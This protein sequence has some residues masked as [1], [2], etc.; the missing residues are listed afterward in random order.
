MSRI[1]IS[2]Q[3]KPYCRLNYIEKSCKICDY[4]SKKGDKSTTHVKK[5]MHEIYKIK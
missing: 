5:V 2:S 3:I 4:N 1:Q